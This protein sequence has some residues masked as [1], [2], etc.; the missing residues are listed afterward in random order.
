MCTQPLFCPLFGALKMGL[1]LHSGLLA[2][3]R[4]KYTNPFLAEDLSKVVLVVRQIHEYTLHS[5]SGLGGRRKIK[6]LRTNMVVF[7]YSALL[8]IGGGRC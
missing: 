3:T 7:R 6:Q 2:R 1:N 4:L 8:G 5:E